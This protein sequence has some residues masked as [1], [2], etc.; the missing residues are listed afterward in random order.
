VAFPPPGLNVPLIVDLRT[1][2]LPADRFDVVTAMDVF[3][4]LVDPVVVVE[5]IWRSLRPGGLFYVRLPSHHFGT[6]PQHIVADWHPTLS[7][8]EELGLVKIWRTSGSGATRRSG[9]AEPA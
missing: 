9:S 4:A 5:A 8:M 1:S 7:R 2:A 6:E 3:E